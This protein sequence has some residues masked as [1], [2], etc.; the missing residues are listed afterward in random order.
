MAGL[1]DRLWEIIV[2]LMTSNLKWM[3]RSLLL[4]VL[5]RPV[6]LLVAGTKTSN[7]FLSS[8]LKMKSGVSMGRS[9]PGLAIRRED[10]LQVT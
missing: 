3:I 5:R 9:C 7:W 1:R 6:L 10:P 2:L 4:A 8:I